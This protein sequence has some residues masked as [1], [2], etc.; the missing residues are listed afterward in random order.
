MKKKFFLM[1]WLFFV[2]V[3]SSNLFAYSGGNGTERYP[4]L[5]SSKADMEQ[6]A[7]NVNGGQTYSGNY[8]LLTRNLT[9]E[10]DAVS[11]VVGNASNRYFSGI[12]DGGG[13]EININMSRINIDGTIYA[14][15][16]GCLSSAIIKN[17]SV[18]G[19]IISS[20][21]YN[22]HPCYAG[23][24]CGYSSNS[25]IINSY[26]FCNVSSS[27]SNNSSPSY[28]GGICGYS[29]S[30]SINDCYNTGNIL[31][32]AGIYTSFAGGICGYSNGNINNCY[33]ISNISSSSSDFYSYSGGICG[34]GG[35]IKNCFSSDTQI[36]NTKDTPRARTGRIG[37][38]N[39]IY[40]NC[41]ASGSTVLING[42]PI[43][44][45]STSSKDGKDIDVTSLQNQSW[46]QSILSWD[47]DNVWRVTEGQEYPTFKYVSISVNIPAEIVYGDQI[48]LIGTSNNNSTPI[49]YTSS[50]NEIAEIFGNLLTAK[51][52]GTV[53]IT[54]SQS[55]SNGY[56]AGNTVISITIQKKALT[57]TAN[58]ASMLY[59]DALPS[60]TCRY[61]GFVSGDDASKLTKQPTYTCNATSQSNADNYTITPSGA[62]SGNYAFTYQ[63][64]ILTIQRRNLRVI[65][66]NTSRIYGYVNPSFTLSYEGFV[67]GET[68]SVLP[69]RPTATTTATI[70]SS[71]GEY[72]ITCSGGET[73]TSNYDFI[74][75][76]GKL[77]ITKAPLTIKADN[78]NRNYGSDNPIFNVSYSGFRNEETKEVLSAQPQVFCA[79]TKTTNTGQYPIIASSASAL[80]YEITYVD[81]TLTINKIAVTAI[82]ESVSSIYGNVPEYSCLYVG[83]VNGDTEDVLTTLPTFTCSA[84]QTSNVGQYSI[85]LSGAEAQNY[86]FT[87]Q[88]GLLTIQK[89]DLLTISNDASKIY[90][91]AN[92]AFTLS[93]TG[94]VNGDTPAVFSSTPI[95][96]TTATIYSNVGEY[97]ISCSGGNATNYRFVY[98]TG[99]FQI[100][101]AAL[102]ATANNASRNYGA[103]NPTFGI[104]YS[105]FKNADTQSSLL[106][107]P[108][109]T[110]IASALSNVGTYPIIVSGGEALNYDITCIN[111]I[112]TINKASLAVIANAV[113]MIYGDNTPLYSCQYNGFAN[114]E[115]EDVLTMLPIFSCNATS[116][117]NAGD[118]TITPSGAEA[119]NYT[120]TY[121][122]GTLTI[123]KRNLRVIPDNASRIYGDANPVFTLSYVGFVNGNNSSDI[124]TKPTASTTANQ[125]SNVGEYNI[126]S[127]GGNATNYSFTYETGKLTIEKADLTIRVQDEQR[128]VGE[129]N[130]PFTLLYSGFKNSE[131][132]SVLDQ[133]PTV[134]CVADANSP[135]GFYN[136]VLSGG[137]DNN[138][139]YQLVNGK[140]EITGGTGIDNVSVIDISLYPNPVRHDLFI[141]SEFPVTK[142]EIYN[143]SGS[144]VLIQTELTEKVDVSRLAAGIYFVKVTVADGVVTKKI[145]VQ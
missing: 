31:S 109:V 104:S 66:T 40:E 75:E 99:K 72:D 129:P 61:E 26:N 28:A 135:I 89:R 64:G 141:R 25:T 82:A 41:Y 85:T 124:A 87:Y 29:S 12:F 92:P 20:T 90:G 100:N 8:F 95:T 9:E 60:Y 13:H 96:S 119:Q 91:D 48:T 44:N 73:E 69:L 115:T 49:T 116:Q 34:Y 30:G 23:G 88:Q 114:G 83:F 51:R 139:N 128:K 21:R 93:Y 138:Y 132:E 136:I 2:I 43:S 108:Q 32:S 133:L 10:N 106:V 35:T 39:G 134:S 111:G 59:G 137:N 33:S 98:E 86:T 19:K 142:V 56:F 80:N 76:T 125:Y 112:L 113:S 18:S 101:K 107:Q 45:Q 53:T 140:L 79:A 97:T 4:Y 94:F 27:S 58:A 71:V 126:T 81:G 131:S 37:G 15:V 38:T 121:Q 14:G 63:T 36:N 102:T 127:S 145:R 16:F 17:L 67:N 24:I 122:S 117:S 7:T 105:G 22:S 74:Y 62:E 54:A 57:V 47:F 42:D 118:Y 123:Q 6:L 5:I 110:C 68:A 70:Y 50:N 1:V 77:T 130:P 52:A 11:T 120:F 84:T 65:P 144:L 55:A 3:N 143:L 103:N 46:L 78:T